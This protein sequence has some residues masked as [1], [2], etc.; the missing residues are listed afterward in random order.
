MSAHAREKAHV[1]HDAEKNFE[2]LVAIYQDI[3]KGELS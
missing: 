3:A 1:T 2:A